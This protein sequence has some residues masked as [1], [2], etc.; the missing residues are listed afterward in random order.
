M[1]KLLCLAFATFFNT[2]FANDIAGLNALYNKKNYIQ[3]YQQSQTYLKT[4][5]LSLP[6]NLI[7][8]DSALK[9]NYLDE[10]MAAYDR[11][12]MINPNN[13]HSKIQIANIYAKSGYEELAIL[14]LDVLLQ[15]PLSKAQK[16]KILMLKK[17]I[18]ASKPDSADN[19]VQGQLSLGLL[20]D[21]NAN[22]DIGEK[23]IKIPAYNLNYQGSKEQQKFALF[24]SINIYKDTS[25]SRSF[26]LLASFDAYNK[27]HI[28]S[29]S[30]NDL[31]YM[32]LELSPH[33]KFGKSKLLLPLFYNKVFLNYD[34]YMNIYGAG[35]GVQKTLNNL[36]L[37]VGYRY[38]KNQFYGKNENKNSSQHNLYIGLR[39]SLTK[40]VSTYTYL[41][42]TRA[43]EEKDLRTDVNYS[44]FEVNTG[45][46]K[47]LTNSF[48]ARAKLNFSKRYYQDFNSVFLNKRLD[49]SYTFNLGITEFINKNSNL[50]LD[51]NYVIKD[52]N[53]FLYEYNKFIIPLIYNYRF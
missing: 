17:R 32:A 49:K 1:K 2:A 31:S 25:L 35:I 6:G 43:Q 5:P 23:S 14:E 15:Q 28:D 16:R 21:S 10:A 53:Q 33:Y 20:Y 38:S 4:R 37:E 3:A 19:K 47:K 50:S 40:S 34:S 27:N 18:N 24:Q 45:I 13:V 30:K 48:I 36:L 29:D 39:N 22:S 8:A 52:S 26:G 46:N 11:V 9:L 12:L 42:Y 51:I 7:F 41:R 44:G